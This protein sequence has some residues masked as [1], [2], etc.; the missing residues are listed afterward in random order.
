MT[1]HLLCAYLSGV[2]FRADCREDPNEGQPRLSLEIF[3]SHHAPAVVYWDSGGGLMGFMKERDQKKQRTIR[4]YAINY[5]NITARKDISR[6][7][8]EAVVRKQEEDLKKLIKR[9]NIS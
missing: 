9:H 5:H 7:F 1:A 6:E 4:R 2:Y 3:C 8:L